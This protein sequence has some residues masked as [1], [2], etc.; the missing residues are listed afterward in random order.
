MTDDLYPISPTESRDPGHFREFNARRRQR[1]IADTI[2]DVE[3]MARHG[4]GLSGA[5]AVRGMPKS[6]LKGYL[7]RHGRY[8]LLLALSA[9]DSVT[10]VAIDN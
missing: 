1:K 7:K 9:N 10:G 2:D 6:R 5:A 3:N 8:D 4:V